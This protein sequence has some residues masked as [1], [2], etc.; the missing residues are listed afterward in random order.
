[1]SHAVAALPPDVLAK[2][3]CGATVMVR[4]LEGR[5]SMGTGF[6]VYPDLLVTNKHVLESLDVEIVD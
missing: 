1:V 4:N 3:A 2:K 5:K 6:F